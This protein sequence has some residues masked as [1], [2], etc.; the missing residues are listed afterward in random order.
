MENKTNHK[1][2]LHVDHQMI[3]IKPIKTVICYTAVCRHKDTCHF[4]PTLPSWRDISEAKALCPGLPCVSILYM[5]AK[6]KS[7]TPFRESERHLE[8]LKEELSSSGFIV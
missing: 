8:S 2:N 4:Q 1:E 5:S 3:I 6:I 7:R